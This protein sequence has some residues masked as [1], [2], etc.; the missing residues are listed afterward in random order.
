[1]SKNQT[2]FRIFLLT[3]FLDRVQSIKQKLRN[4]LIDNASDPTILMRRFRMLSQLSQY[5][6]QI[7]AKIEHLDTDCELDFLDRDFLDEA[8]TVA[9]RDG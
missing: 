8:L 2:F 3:E 1:M 9:S 4:E 6:S 7:I 5:E